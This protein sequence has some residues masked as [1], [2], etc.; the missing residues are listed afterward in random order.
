MIS[1]SGSGPNRALRILKTMRMA[2]S[3]RL[4]RLMK[5]KALWEK[6]LDGITSGVVHVVIGIVRMMLMLTLVTH[7]LGR[8]QV[9][10]RRTWGT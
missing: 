4:L 6:L 8:R 9:V 5:L 7:S 3:L 2:R 10:I 1:Q